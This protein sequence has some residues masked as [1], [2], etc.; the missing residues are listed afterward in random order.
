MA[1]TKVKAEK[2]KKWVEADGLS[3][4]ASTKSNYVKYLS[5]H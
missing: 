1:K 3:D 4:D 5:R 2:I